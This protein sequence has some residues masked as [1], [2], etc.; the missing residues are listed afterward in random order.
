M[1]QRQAQAQN[2]TQETTID[3]LLAQVRTPVLSGVLSSIIEETK[4]PKPVLMCAEELSKAYAHDEGIARLTTED[5]HE[6][7][8]AARPLHR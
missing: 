1:L 5:I 2:Y 7:M 6:I 8:D 3:T 4:N